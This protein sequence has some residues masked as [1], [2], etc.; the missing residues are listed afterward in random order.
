MRLS[1]GRMTLVAALA[2]LSVAVHVSIVVSPRVGLMSLV[3]AVLL[4]GVAM[5]R[6]ASPPRDD[7]LPPAVAGWALV[8]LL[9]QGLLV[10]HTLDRAGGSTATHV[11]AGA[12]LVGV[13]LVLSADLLSVRPRTGRAGPWIVVAAGTAL[14]VV[15]FLT[16]TGL[17]DVRLFQEQGVEVLLSGG[18]PYAPGIFRDIYA[19]SASE[20]F[21][22]PG[23]SVD[24]VLQFGF[25]Y[26]PLGLLL[27]IPFVELA[28]VRLLQAVALL[29]A[30]AVAMTW[31]GG[32]PSGRLA[33]LLLLTSPVAVY[34]VGGG[35]N[36]PLVAGLLALLLLAWDRRRDLAADVLL[37]LLLATKQYAV[38]FVPIHLLLAH[39]L[40]GAD[41]GGWWRPLVPAGAAFAVVTLPFLVRNPEDM[42]FST[43]VLQFLQP[44]RSDSLSLLFLFD[45]EPA[46]WSA[47]LSPL[48]VVGALVWVA[49]RA[50]AGAAG[51]ARSVTLVLTGFLVLSKQAFANYYLVLMVAVA[52]VLVTWGQRPSE[53]GAAGLPRSARGRYRPQARG[54]PAR[55]REGS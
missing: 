15:A 30:V 2:L 39:R 13:L 5:W 14:L 40:R 21:Y 54:R 29:V 51:Y 26:M 38:L 1:D 7:A 52:F 48:A 11:V 53:D 33:G 3:A 31:R 32:T 41:R 4:V 34:V 23:L 27:A 50:P 25:P 46:R 36:D 9:G 8:V 47:L 35:W 28:D 19:P 44:F 45:P 24:G 42:V 43:V 17:I 12:V 49:L 16:R 37:G 18:D 10:V 20:L 55:P 6:T 22:G